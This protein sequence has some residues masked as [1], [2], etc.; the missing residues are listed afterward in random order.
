LSTDIKRISL[1]MSKLLVVFGATGQQGGSVVSH[2]LN[3]AE[4]SKQ[5]K[6]RA[7]T[8]DPSSSKAEALTTKGVEVVKADLS[9]PASLSSALKGAHTIFFLTSP[10]MGPNAKSDELGQGKGV[11]DAAVA[12]GVQYII[13][14]TLPHVERLSGG[15]YTKVAPFDAKAEVEDYIRTLPLKSSF[16]SPAS[17]MQNFQRMMPP[18]PS[19]DGAFV[20]ARPVSPD[21][22]LPLIDTVGD[23]GKYVGAILAEPDKYEGKVFCSASAVY[24]MTEIVE[25]MSK[26]SGKTVKYEQVP[27]ET[28]RSHLPSP[29]AYA[30][31]LVEM[32]FY[33]QH[34]G[35][36][37]P[38][39][40]EL[41][42]WA[43]ENAR[44]KVHSLEDYLR[45][46]PLP[47]LK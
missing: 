4:L 1:A 35:Y 24:S 23:A 7:V 10:S 19:Q 16:F 41:V 42:T 3:D 31:V 17:F 30:D 40:K 47:S 43:A 18:H 20:L 8:R 12:A 9:D 37:G 38:Q 21:T 22:W 39:T 13:F 28:F 29:A 26:V 36:Y 32:M 45:E 25:I 33:Q 27:V 44:G 5:Y 11:A 14:S 2:V 34:F 15:K 46:N 6:V